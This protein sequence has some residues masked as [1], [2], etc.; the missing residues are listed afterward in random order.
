MGFLMFPV[1]TMIYIHGGF[2]TS[3]PFT[4]GYNPSTGWWFG[5]WM[6]YFSIY[7]ELGIIIPTGELIFFRGVEI[8]NQSSSGELITF[9]QCWSYWNI[10]RY[11]SVSSQCTPK[12]KVVMTMF[13]SNDHEC[14]GRLKYASKQTIKCVSE[15][16]IHSSQ[17]CVGENC[18][19]VAGFWP[20]AILA[21]IWLQSLK[22]GPPYQ[23]S[24]VQ[25]HDWLDTHHFHCFIE[26]LRSLSKTVWFQCVKMEFEN[27]S[28]IFTRHLS[29]NEDTIVLRTLK[30]CL[31][32]IAQPPWPKPNDTSEAW[33]VPQA[34][35]I[36]LTI[37]MVVVTWNL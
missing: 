13:C 21:T 18:G 28:L 37:N 1:R 2:S 11:G 32:T 20:M 33:A 4:G 25:A 24:L 15:M 34:A 35:P 22:V 12:L 7:W 36:K 14:L 27:L 5:T 26:K 10:P 31:V 30:A 17:L 6:D 9:L 3:M 8:T 29:F 23:P 19:A 16:H